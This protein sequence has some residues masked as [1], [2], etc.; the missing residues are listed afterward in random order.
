MTFDDFRQSLAATA[1]PDGL[2]HALSGL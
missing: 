1:P 2:T